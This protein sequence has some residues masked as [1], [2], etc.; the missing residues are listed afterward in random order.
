MKIIFL[1][2]GKMGSVVAKMIHASFQQAQLLMYTPSQVRALTL[3]RALGGQHITDLSQLPQC[4]IY[5]VGCKPQQFDELARSLKEKIPQGAVI[6]SLMAAIEVKTIQKK[7]GD[8]LVLR[9]MPSLTLEQKAGIA[10]IHASGESAFVENFIQAINQHGKAFVVSEKDLDQL[11]LFSGCVP[12]YVYYW[13]S[14][15]ESFALEHKMDPQL[16]REVLLHSLRG[17]LLEAA[18]GDL[19]EKIQ[20][21][22]SK[23]GVTE[24]VIR[25]WEENFPSAITEG[26]TAGLMRISELRDQLL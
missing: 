14:K 24:A 1:G 11:T 8:H 10:L 22:S 4:D 16:A 26:L 5:V 2:C 17:P 9:V 20:A 3:A 7:L 21:V 25:E 19:Q 6:L 13:V 12:A 23:K 15:F 18:Q